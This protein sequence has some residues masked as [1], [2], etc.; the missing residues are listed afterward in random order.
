MLSSMLVEYITSHPIQ[1]LVRKNWF[2]RFLISKKERNYE[3]MNKCYFSQRHRRERIVN[4]VATLFCCITMWI[5]SVVSAISTPGSLKLTVL[6]GCLS[7]ACFLFGI[8]FDLYMSREYALS[9]RGITI[10]YAKRKLVF[11]PWESIGHICICVIHQG[12]IESTNDVVI[13]CTTGKIKNVPPNLSRYWNIAEY[14]LMH[15][16]SVL[17]IEYTPERSADF[18]KYSNR[19]IADYRGIICP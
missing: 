16:R 8:C 19:D 1:S 15:F 5:F 10:R 12:K 14:G 13:W 2:F 3:C 9:E 11:Y 7:W 4:I 17:T 6:L 18:K